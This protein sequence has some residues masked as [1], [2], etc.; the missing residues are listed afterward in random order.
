MTDTDTVAMTVAPA[1]DAPTFNS[2]TGQVTTVFAVGASDFVKAVA[3]QPDG[4]IVAVG[5]TQNG[6]NQDFAVARYNSDGSLDTGFGGGSGKVAT[7]I[8]GNSELANGVLVLA[9][10]RILVVGSTYTGTSWDMALVRYNPNGTLDASFGASNGIATS[11]LGA[12][13]EGYGLVV[14]G[15]GKIMVAGKSNSCL[16]Y[17]SPSPRD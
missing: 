10:G 2:G 7:A 4:K 12:S 13:D 17:T 9:D 11:G 5:Y 6:G 14:Q 8:G 15:D 16:L 3:M 1:N